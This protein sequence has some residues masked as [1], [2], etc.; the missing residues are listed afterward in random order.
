MGWGGG[1]VGWVG[2][3]SAAIATT[4][5]AAAAAEPPLH[6]DSVTAAQQQGDVGVVLESARDSSGS[7]DSDWQAQAI[8]A[9]F[10]TH[11]RAYHS[12]SQAMPI[13][14]Y[15]AAYHRLCL[16]SM[17]T[18]A[19]HCQALTSNTI[20]AALPLCSMYP[21]ATS[22]SVVVDMKASSTPPRTPSSLASQNLLGSTPPLTPR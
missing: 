15:I 16:A 22:R 18:P 5:A 1:G 7:A 6:R 8:I 11:H 20:F 10:T 9:H 17:H 21:S 19:S 14:T 12:L 3:G 4:V 2:G 13:A